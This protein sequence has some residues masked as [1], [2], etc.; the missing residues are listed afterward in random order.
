MD[1]EKELNGWNQATTSPR[2]NQA[3]ASVDLTFRD[4]FY[5][6]GKGKRATYF[7]RLRHVASS[8]TLET[9]KARSEP[10]ILVKILFFLDTR[11]RM[12]LKQYFDNK[13]SPIDNLR[14]NQSDNVFIVT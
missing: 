13:S 14:C 2:K 10:H 7:L 5:T 9:R 6:I 11:K 12:T 1:V 8:I 3:S 4:V